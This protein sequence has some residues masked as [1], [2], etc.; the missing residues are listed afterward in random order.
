MLVLYNYAECVHAQ[1][2]TSTP[3]CCFLGK[4]LHVVMF[5]H[6]YIRMYI[7]MLLYVCTHV[8]TYVPVAACPAA[9]TYIQLH[10]IS[11]Y[12]AQVITCPTL[13][14]CASARGKTVRNSAAAQHHHGTTTKNVVVYAC[15]QSS[16]AT[17]VSTN[18][19][20]CVTTMFSLC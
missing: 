15:V 4:G 5:L 11:M 16:A 10:Y 20:T 3:Q 1:H 13:R 7:Y 9:H 8:Y 18:Q 14:H 6:L 12:I 2:Q 19:A 17:A